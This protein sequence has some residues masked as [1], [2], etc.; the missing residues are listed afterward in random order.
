M[1]RYRTFLK[2]A[3]SNYRESDICLG[4]SAQIEQFPSQR[5]VGKLF[6]FL[7]LHLT[8]HQFQQKLLDVLDHTGERGLRNLYPEFL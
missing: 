3:K 7:V 4:L 5:P 6:P 1:R 8:R 2:L